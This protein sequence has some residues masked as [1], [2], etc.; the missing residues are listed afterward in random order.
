MNKFLIP[1]FT[2]A[3]VLALGIAALAADA[4]QAAEPVKAEVSATAAEA[5]ANAEPAKVMKKHHHKHAKKAAVPA[6]K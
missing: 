1:L 5:T 3:G 6:E 4:T 2:G